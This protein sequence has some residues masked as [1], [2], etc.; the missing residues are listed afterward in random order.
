MQGEGGVKQGEV[1][2]SM[3]EEGSRKSNTVGLR[4]PWRE[5]G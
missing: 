3:E 5:N 1:G 4:H 2:E